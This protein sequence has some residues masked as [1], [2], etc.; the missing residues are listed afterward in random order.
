MNKLLEELKGFGLKSKHIAILE[1]L[2]GKKL[3]AQAICRAT[4]IP[5]GR[6]YAYLN[7][8]VSVSLIQ[9]TP[10]KPYSYV[11]ENISDHL[12]SFL[13][14]KVDELIKKQQRVIDILEEKAPLE[15][16]EFISSG[17][18][19]GFKLMQLLAE[20]PY[21]KTISRHASIPFHLY[22]EDPVN[23]NKVRKAIIRHRE[24][25]AHTSHE[26]TL[27]IYKAQI[28]AHKKGKEMPSVMERFALESN[29]E[30]IKKVYGKEY[31]KQMIKQIQQKIEQQN[32]QI[33]V[34]DEYVPMQVYISPKKV[35][36]SI[37]HLGATT[38]VVI[39]S[40]RVVNLYEDLFSDMID[41]A[42]PIGYYLNKIER[43][44]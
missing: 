4:N 11:M 33:Y 27:L 14:F 38:G 3:D 12:S 30:I 16:I 44:L 17:N 41:R 5:K 8:L 2:Y 25:L 7:D 32:I 28:E 15:E 42:R 35:F 6:I 34:V 18:E 39:R 26:M 23:Y 43:S 37:I 29:F 22:P 20:S 21:V 24:T 40:N 13:K 1:A 31:L 9:R 36:L 10:K 19:F